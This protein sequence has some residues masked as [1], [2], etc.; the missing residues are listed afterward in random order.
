MVVLVPPAV[1]ATAARVWLRAR[2]YSRPHLA[3]CASLSLPACNVPRD[4]RLS[5]RY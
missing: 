4:P 1:S 2:T 3:N 5:C